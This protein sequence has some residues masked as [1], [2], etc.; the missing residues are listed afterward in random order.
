MFGYVRPDMKELKVKEAET[1]KA[2]YCGLCKV[3][4]KKYPLF[5]RFSLSYDFVFFVFLHLLLEKEKVS[6]SKRIC[7]AHPL[8]KKPMMDKNKALEDAADTSVIML[9]YDL[10]DKISDRDGI[11]S[12][13]ARIYL[14][15]VKASYKKAIKNKNL[16]DLSSSISIHLSEL[17]KDEKSNISSV[18]SPAEKF[19]N[20]LSG[21]LSYG[22]TG[23]KE[24][25]ISSY[26]G[27]N[28][29]KWIYTVDALD[30]LEKDFAKHNFNPFLSV[31]SSPDEA[32]THLD[33]I[34][35][36]LDRY[37]FEAKSALV[38]QEESDPGVYNIL[39]NILCMGM[40]SIHD[41]IIKE[42]RNDRSL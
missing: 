4:S 30:D 40:I 9:Y 6:F 12:F 34:R 27:L 5:I 17:A 37:A 41:G 20:I 11:K 29:G 13:L 8:K 3:I 16:L 1:Y 42:K 24:K 38:L 35:F 7:I 32:K 19:G 15:F 22:I 21:I 18:D 10:L 31:Y 36:A 14:P 39:N 28:V 2:A 23:H 33:P 26:I 25:R